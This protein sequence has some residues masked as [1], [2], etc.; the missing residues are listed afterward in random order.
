M[1]TTWVWIA[2]NLFVLGMLAIDLGV[3]HRTAHAV[4]MREAVTWSV[5][6]IGLALVFNAGLYF[7]WDTIMPASSYTNSEAA[8]AF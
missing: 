3:F 6:W 7:Y 2:F 5:V 8:I 1:D 4:S